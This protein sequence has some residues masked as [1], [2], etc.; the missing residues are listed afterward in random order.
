MPLH[1][2][3]HGIKDKIQNCGRNVHQADAGFHPA[4]RELRPRKLQQ[5][6]NVNRR[7]IEKHPMRL[8]SVI[9]QGLAMIGHDRD[10]GVLI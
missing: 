9:A 4:A 10:Q 7:V 6:R 2:G 5:Q 8:F 3:R 1:H